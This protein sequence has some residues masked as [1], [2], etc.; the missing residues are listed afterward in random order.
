MVKTRALIGKM[1]ACVNKHF[2]TAMKKN[3]DAKK[4][5]KKTLRLTPET[6]FLN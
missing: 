4:C 3:A 2:F 5:A 1:K 6:P